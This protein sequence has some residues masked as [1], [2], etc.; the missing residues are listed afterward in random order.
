MK[1]FS[2]AQIT[3]LHVGRKIPFPSGEVDLFDQL[4][5][6]IDHLNNFQPPIDMAMVTGD[7]VNHGHLEDYWRVKNELDRLNCPYFIAVGNHDQ[8]TTLIDIFSDHPYLSEEGPFIQY[9]IEDKP[10]RIIV[11]DTLEPGTHFGL[12]DNIIIFVL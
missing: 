9:A 1:Y 3:D 2:I 12:L 6:T 7:L 4:K 11:L 10:I 8:R 5:K